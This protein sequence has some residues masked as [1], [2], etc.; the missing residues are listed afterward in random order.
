MA[1][2]LI[3]RLNQM[4]VLPRMTCLTSCFLAA[5]L[6]QTLGLPLEAVG[7]G[8]QMAQSSRTPE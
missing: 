7:G 6:A 2:H 5:L 8:S 3:R 4:Q 1:D